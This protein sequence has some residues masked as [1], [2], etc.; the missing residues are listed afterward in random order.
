[1]VLTTKLQPSGR[2]TA[3]DAFNVGAAT[4]RHLARRLA[5]A[6]FL[7]DVQFACVMPLTKPVAVRPT[8]CAGHCAPWPVTVA[9]PVA[10]WAETTAN[11]NTSAKHNILHRVSPSLTVI[12]RRLPRHGNSSEALSGDMPQNTR[13]DPSPAP[14]IATRAGSRRLGTGPV[15]DALFLE[16]AAVGDRGCIGAGRNFRARL[17]RQ[18][19]GALVFEDDAILQKYQLLKMD[20]LGQ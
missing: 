13:G 2:R 1:M 14:S 10:A 11:G 19:R 6:M 5:R 8:Y 12:F 9:R 15:S 7:A 18:Q 17:R 4:L 20:Q 16:P 3:S